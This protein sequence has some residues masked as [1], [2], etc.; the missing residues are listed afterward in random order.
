VAPKTNALPNLNNNTI[1]VRNERLDG[2][3]EYEQEVTTLY[4]DLEVE[5]WKV[6][7][8]AYL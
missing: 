2:V 4:K 1:G 6:G 7:Q 8:A 5:C 3:P